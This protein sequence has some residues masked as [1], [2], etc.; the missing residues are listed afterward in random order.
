MLLK[1]QADLMAAS[2]VGGYIWKWE[3]IIR[4]DVNKAQRAAA[5]GPELSKWRWGSQGDARP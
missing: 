3:G 2:G 1:W 5:G 4:K